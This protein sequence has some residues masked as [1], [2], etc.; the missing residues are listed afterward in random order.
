MRAS[1]RLNEVMK[2]SPIAPL[3]FVLDKAKHPSSAA[4]SRSGGVVWS[5]G[6][7]VLGVVR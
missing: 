4:G 1:V 6:E 3:N 2:L 7:L 5:V